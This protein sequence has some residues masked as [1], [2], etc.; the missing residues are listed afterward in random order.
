MRRP[1]YALFAVLA[2]LGAGVAADAAGRDEPRRTAEAAPAIHETR[3]V[4]GA[5][6]VCPELVRSGTDVVTRLTAGVATPGDVVVRAAKLESFT[7]LGTV[8]LDTGARVG[9]LPFTSDANVAAVV[10]ASGDQAGGLEVEQVSRGADGVRRGWAGVRCEAPSA[11]SWFVGAGTQ[12]GTDSQLVLVNPYDDDA[13]VRV[14]LYGR[15]G[16]IDIPTLDGIVVKARGRVPTDL[17][18]LAPDEPLLTIRV[19][20]REGRVASAVRVQRQNATTPLGVDWLPRLA[21]PATT[22]DV[23]GVPGGGEG[24][25]RLFVHAPGEDPVHLRIQFTTA[26]E[27]I[28][29]LGFEDI[30]VQPGKPA[31]IDFT[32]ATRAVVERTGEVTQQATALRIVAEGGPIF[33]TAFA[34]HRARFLPI[35]EISY[36]GPAAPLTGP[37]LVTEATNMPGMQC[38]L[39][40]SAPDGPVRVRVSTVLQQGLQGEPASREFTVPQGKLVRFAYSQ[41]PKSRLQAVVVTPVEEDPNPLYVSR[42]VFEQGQRGPLLTAMALATQPTAGY[43]VPFV[44]VDP[45]VALPPARPRED[46]E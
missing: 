40:L 34:E 39:L 19:L 35:R 7:G 30:E 32:A 28:V 10:T 36:V 37:T 11:E 5:L 25:R 16:L 22:V 21:A 13:L 2:L 42:V 41:F 24:F 14:E 45:G 1:P 20:A 43:D 9:A 12:Q 33:A 26:E 8:V 27:Q 46:A 23:P 17:A 15:N 29:P 18:T 6:A 4:D 3:P 38:A 31:L 44:G